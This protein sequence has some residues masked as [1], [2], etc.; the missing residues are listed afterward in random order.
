MRGGIGGTRR[1]DRINGARRIAHAKRTRRI[2]YFN[3][4]DHIRSAGQIARAGRIRN[5]GWPLDATGRRRT[6]G[7][8]LGRLGLEK[9][10]IHKCMKK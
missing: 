2:G 10:W 7:S 3:G 9:V 4:A 8:R 1:A 5:S 6:A